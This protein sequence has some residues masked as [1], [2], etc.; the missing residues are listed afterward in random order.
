MP[1]NA[2]GVSLRLQLPVNAIGVSLRLQCDYVRLASDC[3]WC[4]SGV[5]VL[6]CAITSDMPV[7]RV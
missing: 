5:K 1:V 7:V 3:H 2:I 4:E 6:V